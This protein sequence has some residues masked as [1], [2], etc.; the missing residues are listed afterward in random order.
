MST[1]FVVLWSTL[2]T[3]LFVRL[4]FER[5]GGAKCQGVSTGPSSASSALAT[6]L[7]FSLVV[8][9]VNVSSYRCEIC[10]KLTCPFPRFVAL[11][12]TAYDSS[13]GTTVRPNLTTTHSTTVPALVLTLR[14]VPPIRPV[15]LI[16]TLGCAPKAVKE[17]LAQ[18]ERQG[19]PLN[20]SRGLSL[21]WFRWQEGTI[22]AVIEGYR[23]PS[24]LLPPSSHLSC[25]LAF[26]PSIANERPTPACIT[27]HRCILHANPTRHPIRRNLTAN[28]CLRTLWK[29]KIVC[30]HIESQAYVLLFLAFA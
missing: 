15:F 23:V 13:L 10:I 16:E 17:T 6:L 21:P 19:P 12:G 14:C 29:C 18:E 26:P 22:G 27:R 7:L 20:K 2:Q 28:T 24:S 8:S 5:D 9:L 3:D 4:A 25:H 1:Y 30:E 11:L